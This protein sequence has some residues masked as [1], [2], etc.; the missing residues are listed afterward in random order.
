MPPDMAA[1]GS[2][3]SRRSKLRADW[4]TEL[5]SMCARIRALRAR[6]AAYDPRLAYI[7]NQNGMFSML[8]LTPAQVMGLREK[9]G[10]YMAGSGRFNVVG[11]S[12]DNAD[13]FAAAI[14]EAM[15]G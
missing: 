11:L 12:D 8:P 2:D 1:W 9:H 4:E 7:D 3:H 13:R 5:Q 15:D 6:L 14:V 10:I